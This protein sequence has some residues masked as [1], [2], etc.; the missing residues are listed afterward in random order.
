[1]IILERDKSLTYPRAIKQDK[2]R[3]VLLWL[4]EFRFSSIEIL[5]NRIGQTPTN[6]NRF[7]NSLIADKL[8]ADFKNVHTKG[9]RY[10]I[11]TSAA[12]SYLEA[13]DYDI[14][15]AVTRAGNFGRYSTIVHDLAV[16]RLVLD[17]LSKYNEVIADKNIDTLELHERPD[18]LLRTHNNM[19]VAFEF[20]RWR[21]SK[22]R[23]YFTFMNHVTALVK[24]KAY[25][26]V[27]YFFDKEVDRKRYLELFSEPEWPRY[28]REQKSGRLKLLEKPFNP[29]SIEQLRKCFIFEVQNIS[30]PS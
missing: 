27:Y 11:L 28:K 9:E 19:W 10:F 21:K 8:I 1:M 22:D 29:D 17:R 7:F 2:L 23:I 26:G 16:Q 15:N 6:A 24:K 20:E 30:T 5:A 13:E 3:L 4:L 18:A 14:S 25:S 12:A